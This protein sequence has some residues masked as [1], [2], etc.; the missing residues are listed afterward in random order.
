MRLMQF[1]PP[2]LWMAAIFLFSTSLFSGDNTY[3]ILNSI[4]RT[5]LPSLGEA[6]VMSVHDAIR[7]FGHIA[8]Y[9]LLCF[10][11]ARSFVKARGW[12]PGRAAL[13]AFVISVLYAATDEYHQGFVPAREASAVD[14]AID[15]FG[16]GA[17]SVLI[18]YR[19]KMRTSSAHH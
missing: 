2:V 11:W 15:S 18:W 5:L 16:A 7:K 14:V 8:E 12:R 3:S 6:A 19:Q 4:I 9:M 13:A 17:M 10:L 1:A